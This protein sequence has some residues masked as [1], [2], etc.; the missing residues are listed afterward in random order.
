MSELALR[1]I[2]QNRETR[3]TFLDLGNCGLTEIPADIAE[4]TWLESVTFASEW[5]EYGE[6]NRWHSKESQTFTEGI[7]TLPISHRS[8]D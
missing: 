3:G 6:N 5:H 4:L 1:L 8:P 2:A 7:L